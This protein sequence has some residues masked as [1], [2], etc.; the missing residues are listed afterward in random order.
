MPEILRILLQQN[1]LHTLIFLLRGFLIVVFFVQMIL[2][3][4]VRDQDNRFTRFFSNLTAPIVAPF[5]RIIPPLNVGGLSLSLGFIA[6]WWS[7]TI[8]TALLGQALPG[9]W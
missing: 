3:F 2:S 9:G 1:I 7:V 6:G 8:V 4:V 5:E